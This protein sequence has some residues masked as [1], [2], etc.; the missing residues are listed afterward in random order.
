VQ[1]ELSNRERQVMKLVARG[2]SNRK[3]A[4]ELDLVEGTVKIHLHHVYKKLGVPNRVALAL[5][6]QKQKLKERSLRGTKHRP[7]KK[8]QH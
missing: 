3:I 4:D 5:Q 2:F 6:V 8:Y 1:S 7:L